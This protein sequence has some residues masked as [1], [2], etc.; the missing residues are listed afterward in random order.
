[1]SLGFP[2]ILVAHRERSV[3]RLVRLTLRAHGYSIHEAA[4]AEEARR[5]LPELAPGL[6]VVEGGAQII[7]QLRGAS[8]VPMVALAAAGDEI[9]EALDAGA[10]DCLAQPFRTAELAARIRALLRRLDSP[11]RDPFTAGDLMVDL[12]RRDVRARDGHVAL[13]PTEFEVLRVLVVNADRVVPYRE[14]VREVW[15]GGFH[16]DARHLLRVNV[17]KL[18][19][20]IEAD[21]ARPR[22]ILTEIGVGYRLCAQPMPATAAC[23]SASSGPG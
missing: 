12:A 6:L 16:E 7:G 5:L 2:L 10:D 18:R 21:P 13:T 22:Y 14:L 3:R 17:N 19:R 15:G 4:S 20:K 8:R 9:V 11:H 1:M 23:I